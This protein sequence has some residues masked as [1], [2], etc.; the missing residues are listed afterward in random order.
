MKK[1]QSGIERLQKQRQKP[2]KIDKIFLGI[3]IYFVI[4]VAV[5]WITYW[6]KGDVPEPLIQYGLG[7]GSVE[8]VL[9]AAI[10]IFSNKRGKNDE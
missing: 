1:A 10:E 2:R 4:F 6:I 5:A 7:G 3:A 9:T 8:L